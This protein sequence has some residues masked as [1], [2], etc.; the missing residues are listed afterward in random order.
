MTDQLVVVA[1][2]RFA[3]DAGTRGIVASRAEGGG[4]SSDV[5]ESPRLPEDPKERRHSA[6]TR[7]QT[8]SRGKL[9]RKKTQKMRKEMSSM[10]NRAASATCAAVFAPSSARSTKQ[11]TS[12]KSSKAIGP[13]SCSAATPKVVLLI[14]WSQSLGQLLR[15]FDARLPY[16]SEMYILADRE[17]SAR[18]SDM[19]ADGIALDGSARVARGQEHESEVTSMDDDHG[20]VASGIESCGLRHI[21]IRHVVGFVTDYLALR[22]LPVRRADIAV[23]VVQSKV[24]PRPRVAAPVGTTRL[25]PTSQGPRRLSVAV[26]VSQFSLSPSLSL[27]CPSASE[28]GVHL[29]MWRRTW[30][31]WAVGRESTGW[32]ALSWQTRRR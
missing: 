16:G 7:I 3:A 21:R 12:K 26:S 29:G 20:G 14:G 18:Q 27:L 11:L 30:E 19:E 23:I 32:R 6:A 8:S 28:P 31:T 13:Q 9:A 4:G 25:V 24:V 22:R 2:D 5:A 17:M 1:A 10:A 15:A